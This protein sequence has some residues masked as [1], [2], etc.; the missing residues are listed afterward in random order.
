M[1]NFPVEG[2]LY[3]GNSMGGGVIPRGWGKN[4]DFPGVF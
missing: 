1:E 4:V 3:S 2:V